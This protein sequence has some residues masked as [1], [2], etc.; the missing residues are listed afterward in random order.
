MPERYTAEILA[1]F[2]VGV[3]SSSLPEGVLA[4]AKQCVLDALGAAAAGVGMDSVSALRRVLSRRL[5]SGGVAVWYRPEK[6]SP[7]GAAVANS[8]AASALDVDDGHRDAGGH[9]GAA[10]IPAAMAVAEHTGASGR[11]FLAALALGYEIAVRVAAARDFAALDT[12]ST[13]RWAAYGVAAAAAR[14][15]NLPINHAAQAL[16]VAGVLS[17]GLSAAGYSALMGN[18]VKEGIPWATLTGLMAVDLASEGFTGPTDILDHPAY[19][20]ARR[21]LASLGETFA[22]Q[23]TYFKPYACCRW[24]HSALDALTALMEKGDLCA[25]DMRSVEVHTFSRALTL[26]NDTDPPS[27]EAAQYSIPFCLAVAAIRGKEALLPLSP[28]VLHDPDITTWA[29][30][31][32]LHRDDA[33]DALFPGRTAARIRVITEGGQY[34]TTVLDPL[35]DPVNP[36]P[37]PLLESKFRRLSAH[38]LP[39]QDQDR[40]I[41][42]VRTLEELPSLHP[43]TELLHWAS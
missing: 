28:S 37:E 36:M 20:D 17:P 8:G 7:L 19:Y 6:L 38:A 42:L 4:A 39:P 27:L 10:V 1:D 33:L 2:A 13:G 34:E 24:I 25:R 12:L 41:T 5:P 43:I 31:V 35:G 16:A 40:L 14:L 26:N 18:S 15:L 9:P 30:R 3:P 11:D 32:R 21:I 29:A 23:R 22:V